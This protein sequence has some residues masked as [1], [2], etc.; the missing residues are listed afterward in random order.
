MQGFFTEEVREGVAGG[1]GA[2][3]G[4]DVVTLNGQRALLARAGRCVQI[5]QLY[6]VE[7]VLK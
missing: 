5:T 1:R 6:K 7:L 4:F 3:I 2:R